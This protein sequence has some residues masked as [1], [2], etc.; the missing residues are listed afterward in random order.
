MSGF[1]KYTARQNKQNNIASNV[2]FQIFT[3]LVLAIGHKQQLL[4]LY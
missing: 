4:V 2:E 1:V 3:K